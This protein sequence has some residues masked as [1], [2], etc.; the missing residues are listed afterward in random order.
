MPD[1][2]SAQS[3]GA[4]ALRQLL[5]DKKVIVCVGPGGVGKTTSAAALAIGA[6]RQGRRCAVLTIDP[7]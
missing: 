6:A 2:A 7:G 3:K 4:A 1:R 5:V